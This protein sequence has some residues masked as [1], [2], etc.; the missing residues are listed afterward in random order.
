MMS[1]SALL[2]AQAAL[3]LTKGWSLYPTSQEA[4][5]APMN[6]WALQGRQTPLAPVWYYP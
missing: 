3:T 5:W 1:V 4:E 2:H 6:V